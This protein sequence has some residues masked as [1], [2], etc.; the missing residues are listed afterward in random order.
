MSAQTFDV[1]VIGAGPAGEV[2]AGRL[3]GQG[4]QVAILE[5]ELVGGECSG[6][7][8]RCAGSGLLDQDGTGIEQIEALALR[9]LLGLR[10]WLGDDDG[11]VAADG[12]GV[13]EPGR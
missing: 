12:R 7:G 6:E 3:A 4:H 9:V 1:I 11:D 8:H 5:S 10:S 13:G 2:L